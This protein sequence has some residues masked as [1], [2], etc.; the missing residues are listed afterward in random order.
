MTPNQ[1]QL[2]ITAPHTPINIEHLK[3]DITNSTVA[4]TIRFMQQWNQ[5]SDLHTEFIRQLATSYVEQ[6]LGDTPQRLIWAAHPG[7]GKTTCLRFFLINVI[8]AW[9]AERIP[10]HVFRG[11]LVCSNQV[12]ELEDHILFLEE[13]LGSMPEV[14]LYH[15][16]QDSKDFK[17]K[18]P[19][20]N[21]DD[22]RSYPLLF[23]TQNLIRK[24]GGNLH[25]KMGETTVKQLGSVTHTKH[26]V[27]LLC[28][29]EEAIAA[30]ASHINIEALREFQRRHER[31]P[32]KRLTEFI[33]LIV[34]PVLQQ[35]DD[36]VDQLKT[37]DSSFNVFFP[38][39]NHFYMQDVRNILNSPY[40]SREFGENYVKQARQ[41]ADWQ[42][43]AGA[44]HFLT[45]SSEPSSIVMDYVIE[46]PSIL[47]R[48]IVT[49]ASA[50]VN[51]LIRLDKNL[52]HAQFML[53][54]GHELK[55]Y[56]NV[57]LFIQAMPSGRTSF[58]EGGQITTAW[59]MVL[60]DVIPRIRKL[61]PQGESLVI[62]FK[63]VKANDEYI[64]QIQAL[65]PDD[66]LKQ[67]RFTTYGK[68]RGD[69]QWSDCTSVFLAGTLHRD[70]GE[71]ASLARGQTR[72]PLDDSL[73]PYTTKELVHSQT[74]SDIQQALSRGSCRSVITLGSNTHA[75]PM[76]AFLG[77][78]KTELPHVIKHL[79]E[80][81]PGIQIID[82]ATGESLVEEALLST[83]DKLRNGL[84]HYL[85]VCR[86]DKVKG[87]VIRELLEQQLG[88]LI[89]GPTW[90]RANKE[91][92]VPGWERRGYT[93]MRTS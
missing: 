40:C 55:R 52:V 89:S 20:V 4:Q 46:I 62:T 53:H 74:A 88:I 50:A 71:L 91:V 78:S 11:I 24:R 60:M 45:N 31:R 59:K 73:Q 92:F 26:G 58:L 8:K 17:R 69:N 3:R 72:Q 51:K 2:D 29:D 64:K 6:L 34:N 90:T 19:V 38:Q 79:R 37:K 7:L 63:G 12:I 70:E 16:K 82:L 93:W 44:I 49:D 83:T 81:F 10:D 61:S 86:E 22:L 75:K 77:L 39:L 36:G 23:A 43:G 32:N 30:K 1:L 35:V 13:H 67:T 25:R 14:G 18:V 68:H 85:Q 27:R 28:W 57:K 66:D 48:A 80:C 56:D 33:D 47:D 41:L 54:H 65:I 15:Q 9:R 42:G 87:V 5:L 21:A 84:I 76:N